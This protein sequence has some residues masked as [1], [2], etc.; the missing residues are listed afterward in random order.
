VPSIPSQLI[1][2]TLTGTVSTCTGSSVTNDYVFL[3]NSASSNFS[4]Y[5]IISITPSLIV[6]VRSIA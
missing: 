6:M 2:T 4:D 1:E 3:Y 5:E